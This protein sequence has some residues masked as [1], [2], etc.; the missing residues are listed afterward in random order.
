[1]KEIYSIC[2]FKFYSTIIL[3]NII[4]NSIPTNSK[5]FYFP[6][7]FLIE[8][9]IFANICIEKIGVNDIFFIKNT[10]I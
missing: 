4:E 6:F 10:F 7:G 1:M 5:I 8:K 9:I 3:R 2:K